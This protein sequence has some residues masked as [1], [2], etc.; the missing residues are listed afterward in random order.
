MKVRMTMNAYKKIIKTIAIVL[1]IIS[2]MLASTIAFAQEQTPEPPPT[3]AVPTEAPTEAPVVV[4]EVVPTEAPVVVTEVAPV[5]VTEAAP[6]VVAPTVLDV[7]GVSVY[8]VANNSA[9]IVG[10][11]I[12]LDLMV[13]NAAAV[14][15]SSISLQCTLDQVLFM[16]DPIQAAA[17]IDDNGQ[18][19]P[20]P[21]PGI[22]GVNPYVL[23]LTVDAYTNT[24]T[25]TI[26]STVGASFASGKAES[27]NLR[28]T[29]AGTFNM[30][31]TATVVDANGTTQAVVVYPLSLSI[32]AAPVVETP[33][34]VTEVAPVVDA[35]VTDA[36]VV[37]VPVTDAPVTEVAPE[38]VVPAEPTTGTV[39][40]VVYAGAAVTITLSN[41][42]GMV[43]MVPAN[44]DGSF[45]IADVP[46]G[47]YTIT[48]D[49][50]GYLPAQ[51]TV[52]VLPGN[53][54][55][56][57]AVS[58]IAG[59]LNNDNLSIDAN[60]AALLNTT[61]TMSSASLPP[62]LDLDHNGRIGLGDLRIVSENLG[63]TGPTLW[64]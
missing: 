57:G 3:E 40:G 54:A 18:P 16:V 21:P 1:P 58:L 10:S 51:G 8:F 7:S 43:A 23:P 64:Q 55:T 22:F 29:A 61:Y 11:P 6:V 41:E 52:G 42:V 34:T 33:V 60:D 63:Q 30:N 9:P 14:G 15:I 2:I 39:T 19:L 5:I 36:P 12:G 44:A 28:A 32:Q 45:T 62:E 27:F 46:A 56:M 50:R 17:A 49:A 31:C 38:V 4:T 24:A 47:I 25:V 37:D 35:P 26:S 20:T 59:D 48:A 53:T 13:T